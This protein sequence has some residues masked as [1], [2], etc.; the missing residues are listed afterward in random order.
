L[1]DA[2][3]KGL[4]AVVYA[5]VLDVFRHRHDTA[6]TFSAT[7]QSLQRVEG[8]TAFE[9]LE[10]AR[11]NWGQ[12]IPGTPAD[13]WQWCLEQDQAVLLDLLTFCAAC[14]INSVQVKT[15]RPDTPRLVH[16]GQ[17][18][19]VLHLDMTS[20]FTPTA[21]N[22]FNRIS[23][24][25]ILE[26]LQEARQQPP[27]PAW[28]NLKKAELAALAAREIAATGWLPLPLRQAP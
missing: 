12:R 18:A 26:A 14:T 10:A 3:D 28:A 2:P 24:L 23:K 22:Y 8:S 27:A 17:L 1:L 4:A 13:I 21:E 9:R 7:A 6:L 20:W 5:L 11:E 15:D 25:Q 16:A 19:A